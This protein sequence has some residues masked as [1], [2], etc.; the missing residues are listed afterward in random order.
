MEKKQFI[1]DSGKE[2]VAFYVFQDEIEEYFY[3]TGLLRVDKFI[4]LVIK[5]FSP[6]LNN[7]ELSGMIGIEETTI[8]GYRKA[9]IKIQNEELQ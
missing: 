2:L 4:M 3:K 1:K 9:L 6:I 5:N 8:A 7:K